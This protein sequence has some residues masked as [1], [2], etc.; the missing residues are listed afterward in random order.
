MNAVLKTALAAALAGAGLAAF[1]P[2]P[3]LHAASLA[4]ERAEGLFE[5]ELRVRVTGV[6]SDEGRVWIGV[7]ASEAAYA[8]GQ[9]IA[10][11]TVLADRAGVPEGHE[12][13]GRQ[14]GVVGCTVLGTVGGGEAA[15]RAPVEALL[16]GD[17][18]R[19]ARPGPGQLQGG[20]VGFAAGVAEEQVAELFGH[21]GSEQGRG[22]GANRAVRRV[23][24]EQQ[25]LGLGLLLL[26]PGLVRL[27]LRPLGLP[28]VVLGE[29]AVLAAVVAAGA[30]VSLGPAL[31]A[32]RMSL[33]DGMAV[34][35]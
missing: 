11:T 26:L 19:L 7:Y 24:V 14:H 15:Q 13:R 35:S 29:L 23:G 1:T 30:V 28:P 27:L 25:L 2:A 21:D 3:A 31:R 20:L 9:E 4:A 12:V 6:A 8:A 32:Y 16:H 22:A 33:A 18:A 5:P 34:R 17:H 10:E